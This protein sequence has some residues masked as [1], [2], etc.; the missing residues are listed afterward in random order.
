MDDINNDV[1]NNDVMNNDVMNNNVMNN[2]VTSLDDIS[3]DSIFASEADSTQTETTQLLNRRAHE[4]K[5]HIALKYKGKDFTKILNPEYNSSKRTTLVISILD[6]EATNITLK[7]EK[8]LLKSKNLTLYKKKQYIY[9]LRDFSISSYT[10]NF[11]A[12]KI[13]E[14]IENVGPEKF[15][16]VVFDAEIAMTAAKYLI[17]TQY[18]HILPVN[19]VKELISNRQFWIDVEQLQDIL[20]P[21]K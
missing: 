9:S 2:D 14:V 10:A 1:I 18:L 21:V 4:M 6:V 3:N 19:T 11:N 13:I 20:R 15:V 8:E 16:A 7:I 12:V 17:T 5:T